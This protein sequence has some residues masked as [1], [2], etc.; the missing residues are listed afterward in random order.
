MDYT[1]YIKNV[2][3][4]LQTNHVSY[5]DE[6]A[7]GYTNKNIP[8]IEKIIFDLMDKI[9][10]KGEPVSFELV[11]DTETKY[12]T[13][14]FGSQKLCYH[15]SA[16]EQYSDTESAGIDIIYYLFEANSSGTVFY[17]NLLRN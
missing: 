14:V 11:D 5:D 15:Y 2:V 3:R 12:N 7:V 13:R 6:S 8:Q 10:Y 17:I 16:S 1:K 4:L 9:T